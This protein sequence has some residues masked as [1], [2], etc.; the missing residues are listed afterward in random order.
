MWG[1][2]GR[3]KRCRRRRCVIPTVLC[4]DLGHLLGSGRDALDLTAHHQA[5]HLRK[6]LEGAVDAC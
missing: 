1:E 4:D 3:E 6:V 2:E 5:I